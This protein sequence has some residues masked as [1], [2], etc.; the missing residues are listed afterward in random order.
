VV[1]RL[2]LDQEIEGSNPSAPAKPQDVGLVVST[3]LPLAVFARFRSSP[4][5]TKWDEPAA[6]RVSVARWTIEV[7][8]PEQ[9]GSTTNVVLILPHRLGGVRRSG[10]GRVIEVKPPAGAFL[11]RARRT[12][13]LARHAVAEVDD[14]RAE[15]AGLDA[16][17][18]V[19]RGTGRY[20]IPVILLARLGVDVNEQG[21]RL[22]RALI[23]EVLLRTSEAAETVGARALLIHAESD[24]ARSFYEHLAE[25]EP[26]PTDALHLF[27]LMKDLRATIDEGLYSTS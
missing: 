15:G 17:E 9:D 13:R 16:P 7:A 8:Y 12:S 27:L 23:K 22:G 3:I 20:P 1:R 10:T 21:R 2:T 25:F 26:S 19:A 11:P 14:S 6:T 4:R 24:A 18:R 5:R